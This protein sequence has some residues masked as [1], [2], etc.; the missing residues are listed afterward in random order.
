MGLSL[1]GR[2]AVRSERMD[3]VGP[4]RVEASS[5]GTTQKATRE[6]PVNDL[7]KDR[8]H[9]RQ[10]HAAE[11][12]GLLPDEVGRNAGGDEG[13]VRHVD[14]EGDAAT[15]PWRLTERQHDRTRTYVR[16]TQNEHAF[17]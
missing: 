9:E 1:G 11:G 4:P 13:R 10:H 12:G 2:A 17:E 3:R 5:C 6:R 8:E 14:S 16:Q 7:E 15:E